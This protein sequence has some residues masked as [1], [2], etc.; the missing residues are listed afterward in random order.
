MPIERQQLQHS[1]GAGNF[2]QAGVP[3]AST[4]KKGPDYGRLLDSLGV[5]AGK[6]A[7]ENQKVNVDAAKAAIREATINSKSRPKGMTKEAHRDFQRNTINSV[8]EQFEDQGAFLDI[9]AGENKAV[10]TIDDFNGR[11]KALEVRNTMKQLMVNKLLLAMQEGSSFTNS[12]SERSKQ[13]Y[14]DAITAAGLQN[15]DQLL[16]ED[17]ERT[18][19]L[20][21]ASIYDTTYKEVDELLAPM[22]GSFP[23]EMREDIEFFDASQANMQ[24]NLPAM[25]DALLKKVQGLR[26]GMKD[27]TNDSVVAGSKAAELVIATARRNMMPELLDVA[28][29]DAD[30][31]GTPLSK[32][33]KEEFDKA[34]QEILRERATIQQNLT[35]KKA[36]E[37]Q[38]ANIAQHAEQAAKVGDNSRAALD[39]E[40]DESLAIKALEDIDNRMATLKADADAGK[41]KDNLAHYTRMMD[42][43]AY[44]KNLIG[45]SVGDP[46]VENEGIL[47][48]ENGTL[49]TEWVTMNAKRLGRATKQQLEFKL[50]KQA[51]AASAGQADQ[52]REQKKED[53]YQM[54]KSTDEMGNE[55]ETYMKGN[56]EVLQQMQAKGLIGKLVDAEDVQAGG[57]SSLRR[58]NGVAFAAG[59]ELTYSEQKE[60]YDQGTTEAIAKLQAQRK[61]LD[62]Y[63]ATLKSDLASATGAEEAKELKVD[64]DTTLEQAQAI[65][66]NEHAPAAL[67][68][69][70]LG[71]SIRNQPD[72]PISAAVREFVVAQGTNYDAENPK[73]V[74]ALKNVLT[75]GFRSRGVEASLISNTDFSDENSV[76]RLV[77]ALPENSVGKSKELMKLMFGKDKEVYR[78][79]SQVGA[80]IKDTI[81][82]TAENISKTRLGDTGRSIKA[83]GADYGENFRNNTDTV[84][85]H[86]VDKTVERVVNGDPVANKF[87]EGFNKSTD[88][89]VKEYVNNAKEGLEVLKNS[90]AASLPKAVLAKIVD[91][92][93]KFMGTFTKGSGDK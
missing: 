32:F 78:E 83:L 61:A 90:G 7:E 67:K 71:M 58:A 87:K 41:Y 69:E 73:H 36:M 59:K 76:K 48:S 74:Q 6:V 42:N 54:T 64:D 47:R 16:A 13:S 50:R 5:T 12:I 68:I 75:S 35:N 38:R 33:H 21:M 44:H 84:L 11:A 9:F 60:A 46:A 88:P 18:K 55:H 27:F 92:I 72:L 93:E 8:R 19:Q 65:I 43:L 63:N 66:S 89:L 31:S 4:G 15:A 23:A 82:G 20:G 70:A 79:P 22:A 17:N 25:Q 34:R 81:S 52:I 10:Q 77:R 39:D 45:T 40:E 80:I 14:L 85:T 56:A 1:I 37:V 29:A 62:D 3:L 91:D 49:N 86:T 57:L 24:E 26:T 51:A 53:F 2:G 28:D 30:G